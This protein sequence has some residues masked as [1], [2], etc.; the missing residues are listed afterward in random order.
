MFCGLN[1]STRM[2]IMLLLVQG[3]GACGVVHWQLGPSLGNDAVA[4]NNNM[5]FFV[6]CCSYKDKEYVEQVHWQSGPF[7]AFQE[8]C[9]EAGIEWVEKS[10]VTY[11]EA[12]VG[13]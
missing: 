5:T 6:R 7:K 1:S 12:D 8:A 2:L 10:V 11:V 3:Q 4:L 13:F 9:K